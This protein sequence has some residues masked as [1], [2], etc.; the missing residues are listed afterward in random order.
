MA[1]A[2]PLK[3]ANPMT[4]VECMTI[5]SDPERPVDSVFF[6]GRSISY[7][8]DSKDP[9]A[10]PLALFCGNI[11]TFALKQN[12]PGP[13]YNRSVS[14]LVNFLNASPSI[15]DLN[16]RGSF[17][18]RGNEFP[19]SLLT[20]KKLEKLTLNR[21]WEYQL[22]WATPL[23]QLP[24]LRSLNLGGGK[25][26]SDPC[27]AAPRP[28]EGFAPALRASRTLTE[29][30]LEDTHLMP[31]AFLDIVTASTGHASLRALNIAK[32]V[33]P[34]KEYPSAIQAVCALITT[35]SNLTALD[36]SENEHL[37]DDHAAENLAKALQS[38]SSLTAV[39]LREN[40]F[41]SKGLSSFAPLLE[42]NPR[43]REL[44]LDP[45]FKT[46]TK[47]II[48]E[49]RSLLPLFK[50]VLATNSTIQFLW[51]IRGLWDSRHGGSEIVEL[52]H[53]NRLRARVPSFSGTDEE[54]KLFWA[55]HEPFGRPQSENN[56]HLKLPPGENLA[57][58]CQVT[59]GETSESLTREVLNRNHSLHTI[60][61]DG[62]PLGPE[63]TEVLTT[64]LKTHPLRRLS[65]ASTKIGEEGH[66]ALAEALKSSKTITAVD[67]TSAGITPK[68][69]K[70]LLDAMIENRSLLALNVSPNEVGAAFDDIQT[71]AKSRAKESEE[72]VSPA[73][74][75]NAQQ[76]AAQ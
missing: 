19:R 36:L 12:P 46:T 25:M 27:P 8:S 18:I 32:V 10:R 33:H 29:L 74:R 3:P 9:L 21:I 24:S 38:N 42:S 23:L 49:R 2:A 20:L 65:L 47:E 48:E 68:G 35:P 39:S 30:S 75:Y 52:L 28:C 61:L 16:V 64:A 11:G 4:A 73:I 51:K 1:A 54:L 14:A 5:T 7:Y 60:V 70:A 45:E 57:L 56:L 17:H 67:L 69:A 31:E 72:R 37:I 15:S 58:T 62:N 26:D 13:E 34:A 55:Q 66:L 50:R 43:L 40:R 76:Q 41:R 44:L 59:P 6:G 53:N 22:K 71:L 63:W